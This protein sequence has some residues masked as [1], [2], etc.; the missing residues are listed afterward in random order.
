MFIF[1]VGVLIIYVYD[2]VVV[3][4]GFKDYQLVK[5]YVVMFY[6][7]WGFNIGSELE[8]YFVMKFIGYY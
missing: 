1:G 3:G 7:E 6:Y 8:F 4:Q 5:G 2:I